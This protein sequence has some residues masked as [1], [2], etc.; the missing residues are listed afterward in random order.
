MDYYTHVRLKNEYHAGNKATDD[1]ADICKSLGMQE[2]V[3]PKMIDTKNKL[4]IKCWVTIVS[5]WV[6]LRFLIKV[7][8]GDIL[9][10]QHPMYGA[11]VSNLFI[12]K[13]QKKGCRCIAIIHDLESLRNGVQGE[14]TVSAK[15][16]F[17]SDSCLLKH[18]DIVIC[19]NEKMH[20]YLNGQGFSNDRIVDLTLFDYLSEST[21][22]ADQTECMSI[23]IAGNL[24]KGKS[25]YIYDMIKHRSHALRIHLYGVG[26]DDSQREPN[27]FYE[28]VF[29]PDELCSVI[30]GQY[31]IVWDGPTAKTCAGNTGE[32]LKYNNPHKLSLYIASGIPVIV[33]SQS[34]VARFVKENSLGLVV[35]SLYDIESV[36]SNVSEE[37]YTQFVNQA[38]LFSSKVRSGYYFKHALN[39]CISN[40]KHT[41]TCD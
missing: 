11:R 15:T 12:P 16:A 39:Q 23:T 37:Q 6:W 17:I 27:V 31:G 9:V 14:Y 20:Q 8:R 30:K 10:Y 25:S 29:A 1:I 22:T 28:G 32:Y 40:N 3:F 35:D 4:A 33:W 21:K 38:T 18:F 5:S 26:Y 36:I 19:H 7:K 41:K 13:I 24:S 34:A 2:I